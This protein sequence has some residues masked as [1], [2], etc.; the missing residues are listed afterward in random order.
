MHEPFTV[1]DGEL[2]GEVGCAAPH[3]LRDQGGLA[4][5]ALARDGDCAAV[6]ADDP[7][8]DED[9]VGSPDGDPGSQLTL[10]RDDCERQP[11]V[12][13]HQR[14]RVV[15]GVLATDL[16]DNAEALVLGRAWNTPRRGWNQSL[17]PLKDLLRG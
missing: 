16:L 1:Y 13:A 15:D 7:R 14:L 6:I 17:D 4:R 12:R 9:R 2:V 11:H 3:E 10:D 8:V 5:E